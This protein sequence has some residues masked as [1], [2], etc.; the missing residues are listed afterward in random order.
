VSV[1]AVLLVLAS[2]AA[3]VVWAVT[4]HLR[5]EDLTR[6]DQRYENAGAG[7]PVGAD[8]APSRQHQEVIDR[9]QQ[10]VA[11][12]DAV[13]PRN[14]L[15]A[16][17]ASMDA[18]GD[19]A[20][21]SDIEIHS[22]DVDG[23][24]GE[25][26]CAIAADPARRLLYLHGGAFTL[27]SPRSHRVITSKLSRLSGA[28]VLALDYSLLPENRRIDC[29][30]DSQTSYRWIID[31]GPDGPAP[32]QVLFVAGDSAGGNL[33]LAVIAWARDAGLRP[34][35]AAIALSP[36]TDGTLSGPSMRSN[37]ATDHMLGPMLGKIA[38]VPTS[39]VLWFS[40]ISSRIGPCDPRLSPLHGDLSHLPPTLVQASEAEMLLDDARRYVVKANAAGSQATLET[41]HHMLHVWQLFELPEANA[42]F[43]R[44]AA[45]LE[46]MAPRSLEQSV[47]SEPHG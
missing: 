7:A 15:S 38:K 36:A 47:E 24:P 9:L 29:F 12:A 32:V 5:G 26:V 13:T 17:R 2:V 1:I 4:R 34:A 18:M 46:L 33:A 35:D 42:A 23:V 44:I 3:A 20:D 39:L 41:W 30:I 6:Y 37:V 31:H 27:G 19:D 11:E 16:M 10:M 28:C 25:W 45:F 21:L 8:G 22:V 40:W 14:R 43:A